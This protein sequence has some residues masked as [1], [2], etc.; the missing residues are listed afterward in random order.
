MRDGEAVGDLHRVLVHGA[1]GRERKGE[2]RV[3]GAPRGERALPRGRGWQG[4][5]AA[6]TQQRPDHPRRALVAPLEAVHDG[7]EHNR[8]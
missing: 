2:Q 5:A 4:R 1:C 7:G 3:R 6:L 8:V